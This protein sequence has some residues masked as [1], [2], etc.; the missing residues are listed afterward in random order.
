MVLKKKKHKI[1]ASV[2]YDSVTYLYMFWPVWLLSISYCAYS[3]ET[4]K[5]LV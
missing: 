2:K 3:E 5:P 4:K 1:R